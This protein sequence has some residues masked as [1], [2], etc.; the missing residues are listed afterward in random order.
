[1]DGNRTRATRREKPGC[2]PADTTAYA[3]PAGLEPAISSLTTRRALLAALRKPENAQRKRWESNPHALAG[4]LFS[5][6]VP[7]PVGWL[8]Q[9]LQRS[10]APGRTRTCDARRRPGYNRL[11]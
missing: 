4:S 7:P 5:R 10:G 3:L 2:Q 8:F 9:S 11:Q 6:Q 1:M